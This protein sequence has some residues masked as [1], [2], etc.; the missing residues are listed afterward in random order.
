MPKKAAVK[1]IVDTTV[2]INV[3]Q[4]HFFTEAELFYITEKSKTQAAYD[5]AQTLK[6]TIEEVQ[7]HMPTQA[8]LVIQSDSMMKNLMAGQSKNGSRTGI[9]VMTPQAS[10]FADAT[11]GN[12][13]PSQDG[14]L[15]QGRHVDCIHKPLG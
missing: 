3:P 8:A 15:V 1:K 14:T 6:C 4:E 7:Q 2:E 11:R 13:V 5:I 10:E 9:R 12:R